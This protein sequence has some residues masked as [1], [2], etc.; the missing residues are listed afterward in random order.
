MAATNYVTG[1]QHVGIPTNDME[2][3]IAFYTALGFTLKYETE[4]NGRVVFFEHGDILIETYEKGGQAVGFR[5]AIDHIAL[6]VNDIE[7]AYEEVQK[8]GYP[9]VEGPCFLPF[10]ENGVKY[11]CVQGPNTEIVEFLQKL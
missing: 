2:A 1:Y 6:A 7:K 10:W 4:N 3:T 8:T 9:V 5:G 11:I